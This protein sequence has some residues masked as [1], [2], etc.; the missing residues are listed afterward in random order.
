MILLKE[1]EDVG[2]PPYWQ[3]LSA[4]PQRRT[5]GSPEAA[6][7]NPKYLV[8]KSGAGRYHA[9]KDLVDTEGDPK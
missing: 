4:F 7:F 9:I 3:A 6:S 1:G 8:D 2:Q 5:S